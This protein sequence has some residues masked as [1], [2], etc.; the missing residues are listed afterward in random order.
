MS[1]YLYTVIIKGIG[2]NSAGFFQ[3]GIFRIRCFMAAPALAP[4]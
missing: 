2:D 4:A 1:R 3:S